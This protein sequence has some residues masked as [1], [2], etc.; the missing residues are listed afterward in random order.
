MDHLAVFFPLLSSY[1]YPLCATMSAFED[2]KAL[3]KK[4]PQI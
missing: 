4:A 3:Q 1:I 2:K